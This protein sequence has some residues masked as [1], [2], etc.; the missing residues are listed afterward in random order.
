MDQALSVAFTVSSG[1][2]SQISVDVLTVRTAIQLATGVYGWFKG[3]ETSKNLV[4]QLEAN[5]FP[6][7]TTSSFTLQHYEAIRLQHQ[8]VQGVILE[9]RLLRTVALPRTM[10]TALPGNPGLTC[11]RALTTCLLCLCN[12]KVAIEMLRHL[13]P[14]ALVQQDLDGAA[15]EIEG[16]LL[17]GLKQW[18]EQVAREEARDKFRDHLF[19]AVDGDLGRLQN[20]AGME[21]IDSSITDG[22]DETMMLG[23]LKWVLTPVHQRKSPKYPTRSLRA[24]TAA[25]FMSRM[26]FAVNPAYWSV[27]NQQ[28]FGRRTESTANDLDPP[29]VILVVATCIGETDPMAQYIHFPKRFSCSL[30]RATTLV[31]IPSLAFG[32]VKFMSELQPSFSRLRDAYRQA[33]D[34]ARRKIKGVRTIH[35]TV[36]VE[37][38]NPP[39]PE[40]PP[41][42]RSS[43]SELKDFFGCIHWICGDTIQA[44]RPQDEL[45]LKDWIS[46]HYP[47]T[48]AILSVSQEH[49][50]SARKM[51]SF[52]V[53]AIFIGAMY[54]LCSKT[55][56]QNDQPLDEDSEIAFDPDLLYY[57]NGR[58]I[59]ERAIDIDCLLEN[60]LPL[61][62][63]TQLLF[64]MFACAINVPKNG[65]VRRELQHAGR[66]LG[67][68]SHGFTIVSDLL[69]S[70]RICSESLGYFHISRG[71]ALNLP[72]YDDGFVYASAYLPFAAQIE[73]ESLERRDA[74]KL[75][76]NPGP[77]PVDSTRLDVEPCWED[78][79]RTIVLA[80]RQ[81]G[82]MIASLNLEKILN[83]LEKC[84]T[85]CKCSKYSNE[86][87][88]PAT[89]QWC[90]LPIGNLSKYAVRGTKPGSIAGLGEGIGKRFLID[91]SHSTEALAYVLGIVGADQIFIAQE[92]LECAYRLCRRIH[93]DRSTAIII[94]YGNIM[95][96]DTKYQKE[97]RIRHQKEHAEERERSL[98]ERS[99][100]CQVESTASDDGRRLERL[101]RPVTGDDMV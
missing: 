3:P 79:S 24:W 52:T 29:H 36:Q 49:E 10:S 31:N 90:H 53:L 101:Q 18:V 42:R 73:N 85:R 63:W 46:S 70:L 20:A 47:Q 37:F 50:S 13:I 81:K 94:P 9:N 39:S 11:L 91:G 93:P 57:E 51:D 45:A 59:K 12:E 82:V 68:H 2:L 17:A 15:I 71:Q 41:S 65:K 61:L 97:E 86:I 1:P 95:V 92:C 4:Q 6:L 23:V 35:G 21:G 40:R 22:G 33:F 44:F 28:D 100:R 66:L 89:E 32:H 83:R 74:T 98:A 7:V 84:V 19:E 56:L 69:V 77:F 75:Y 78:D 72:T 99:T 26:G 27:N 67:V 48:W 87:A 55:C 14:C 8:A 88:V 76:C 64:G 16:P 38:I 96:E 43:A 5:G 25:A 62:K 58:Y 30:P 54:G 34:E 80:M 60:G